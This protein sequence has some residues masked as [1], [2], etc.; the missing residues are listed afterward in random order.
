MR[1]A[2]R[3]ATGHPSGPWWPGFITR[4][5]VHQG[6]VQPISRQRPSWCYGTPGLARAQQL[7]GLATGD[8]ARQRT[9]ET[10]LL[11]CLRDRTQLDRITDSGLCH[12]MAG[13]LHTAWRMASDAHTPDI[14]I[15]LPHLS[16]RCRRS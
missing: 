3:L 16:G 9:A 6:H 7:A 5:Q 13:V 4:E 14:A 1:L 15:E 11:G 8:T 10:A 2:G 12:G